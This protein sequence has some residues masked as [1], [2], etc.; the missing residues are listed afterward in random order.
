M[1]DLQN[2]KEWK[3]QLIDDEILSEE[4]EDDMML[5]HL[6]VA[7]ACTQGPVKSTVFNWIKETTDLIEKCGTKDFDE[8]W[9]NLEKGGV[10]KDGKIYADFEDDE[11]ATV[12]FILLAMV[13][14]G[15]VERT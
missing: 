9:F 8:Y 5:C 13:A 3:Q 14:R 10:I 11:T 4:T 7:G 1:T 6:I 15:Y 2:A 12:E